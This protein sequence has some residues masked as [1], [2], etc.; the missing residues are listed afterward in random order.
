[1]M[2][3]YIFM[4]YQ[5]MFKKNIDLMGTF[6]VFTYTLAILLHLLI[7]AFAWF[8]LPVLFIFYFVLWVINTL[9]Q[10]YTLDLSHI[11]G[12]IFGGKGSGKSSLTA[13]M[14]YLN[15]KI[16][17]L[18]SVD[19]GYNEV[20]NPDTYF[21]SI[22]PNTFKDMISGTI[23]TV[24]K[25][26]TWEGRTYFLDDGGIYFPSHEDKD[27]TDKFKSMALFVPI[28]RHLYNSN[29][30][31]NVQDLERIWVKIREL[32]VDGYIKAVHVWGFK[33]RLWNVIPFLHKYVHIK[34]RY[35]ETKNSALMG[36]L[37]YNRSGLVDKMSDGLHM[38]QGAV[39]KELYNATNGNIVEK[40]FFIKKKS[41][42]YDTR[43]FH[44]K[45]FGNSIA[46]QRDIENQDSVLKK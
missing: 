33:S 41:I 6:R 23:K 4:G 7:F 17:P 44:K 40:G 9:N 26:T 3:I 2:Y 46:A 34:Y 21:N 5:I 38:S 14:V 35:Y 1:M 43:L 30:I 19:F 45:F 22:A 12:I 36:M 20:L 32:Q 8:L 42:K 29:T 39:T 25:H 24:I 27:L 15:R 10:I 16:N 11:N 18:G 13:A 28:Q 31:I 37:P